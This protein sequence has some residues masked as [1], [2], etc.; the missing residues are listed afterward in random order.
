MLTKEELDQMEHSKPPRDRFCLGPAAHNWASGTERIKHPQKDI[1]C[2]GRKRC[3]TC[4]RT[5]HVLAFAADSTR[6]ELLYPSCRECQRKK[7]AISKRNARGAPA[8]YNL[9]NYITRGS[10]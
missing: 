3:I 5:L 8:N 2:T 1:P 10:Q 7:I 6:P 4:K 9:M